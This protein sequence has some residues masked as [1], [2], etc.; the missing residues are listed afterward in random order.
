MR[1]LMILRVYFSSTVLWVYDSMALQKRQVAIYP[2][3][4][5]GS[6]AR[7][8]P[9]DRNVGI[10][11]KEEEKEGEYAL[12]EAYVCYCCCCSCGAYGCRESYTFAKRFPT[13]MKKVK[14]PLWRTKSMCV[15]HNMGSK[16]CSGRIHVICSWI[17]MI[18]F[19]FHCLVIFRGQKWQ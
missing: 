19:F 7:V 13:V 10:N 1:R 17:S 3:Q 15:C 16:C 6:L 18:L 5:S 8:C 11:K 12:F 9:E 14:H 4:E 2:P